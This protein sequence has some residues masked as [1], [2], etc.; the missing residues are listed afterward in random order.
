MYSF[1]EASLN[2]LNGRGM[3]STDSSEENKQDL[4]DK[5]EQW[6]TDN[7]VLGAPAMHNADEGLAFDASQWSNSFSSVFA[8]PAAESVPWPSSALLRMQQSSRSSHA[9][10][11]MVR[12]A[13]P[14]TPSSSLAMTPSVF[15]RQ[16]VRLKIHRM[17]TLELA[18]LQEVLQE[19]NRMLLQ[20]EEKTMSIPQVGKM[21]PQQMDKW[22]IG[23]DL[24]LLG[25]LHLHSQDFE[26]RPTCTTYT[27]K[28]LSDTV[29]PAYHVPSGLSYNLEPSPSCFERLFQ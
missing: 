19:V 6:S 29:K 16:S 14:P 7:C 21:L 22:L 2:G 3:R 25:L 24:C 23:Q 8:V 4:E 13:T 10:H 26:I 28:C 18:R 27:V 20:I 1:S 9:D 5:L 12:Q 15:H 17:T 11:A